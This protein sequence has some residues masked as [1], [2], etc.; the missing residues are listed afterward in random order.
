MT[1]ASV[2]IVHPDALERA[3]VAARQVG[4]PFDRVVPLD[5]IHGPRSSTVGPD[6]HRLITYGLTNPPNFVERRLRP[7]E[8]KTKVAFLS[9]SS[10]TTGRPKV[11]AIYSWN[12]QWADVLSPAG[13]RDSSLR[14]YREYYPDGHLVESQRRQCPMGKTKDPARRYRI[15]WWVH[16]VI[17]RSDTTEVS[18]PRAVLPFYR[19]Y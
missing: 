17:L 3:L 13:S 10:G 18:I 14:S 6:L 19:K 16:L 11:C 1:K 7:G 9:F 4:I 5:T 8:G 15:G 2:L 12:K